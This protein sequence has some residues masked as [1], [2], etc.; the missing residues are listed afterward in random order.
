MIA[1]AHIGIVA[2]EALLLPHF[3]WSRLFENPLS[4]CDSCRYPANLTGTPTFL[5]FRVTGE[6]TL[7]DGWDRAV[8]G[9]ARSDPQRPAVARSGPRW[10]AVAAVGSSG[11]R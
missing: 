3:P 7:S 6:G 2:S 9:L 4:S 11:P 10:F 5:P 8:S 1:Q